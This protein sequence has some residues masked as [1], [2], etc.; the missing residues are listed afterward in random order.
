MAVLDDGCERFL[1]AVVPLSARVDELEPKRN[2]PAASAAML[3]GYL[4][5]CC[6]A[7]GGCFPRPLRDGADYVDDKAPGG[8]GVQRL[9]GTDERA[10]RRLNVSI[11]NAAGDAVQLGNQHGADLW[12]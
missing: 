9:S 2:H 11:S 1:F 8:P 3:L 7:L 12:L 6:R 5:R 10:S 4:D